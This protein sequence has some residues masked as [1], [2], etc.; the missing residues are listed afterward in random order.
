MKKSIGIAISLTL[1]VISGV[2][3]AKNLDAGSDN[4]V[5][6]GTAQAGSA[7]SSVVLSQAIE[8]QYSSNV[9]VALGSDVRAVNSGGGRA[10]NSGGGR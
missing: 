6:V 7:V 8:G 3:V 4:S 5:T 1:C 10:V 9:A 2:A